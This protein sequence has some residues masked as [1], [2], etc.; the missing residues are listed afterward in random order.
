VTLLH[1]RASARGYQGDARC[2]DDMRE[3]RS[4]GLRLGL[5]RATAISMNNLGDAEAWY[6]DLATARATWEQAIAFSVERGLIGPA[7]WQRGERLRCL[8]HGGEWDAAL[9]ESTEVL[10]WE[11]ETGAGP[12]EVYAR[13]PMAGIAVH[14]GDLQEAKAHVAA[15][16][17][18]ARRSG[19]PQVL[20][21]GLSMAALVASAAGDVPSAAGYL[22][23]LELE[24]RHQSAWRSYCRVEPLRVAVALK[25]IDLG[26]AFLGEAP[27]NAGWDAC[28]YAT[29]RAMLA[30]ARGDHAQAGD[31]YRQAAALWGAYGSMLERGYALLGLGRCGDAGAAR[32]ADVIFSALGARPVLAQAA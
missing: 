13:L 4:L 17:A 23:E 18:A 26:E 14:R 21:P 24:T 12:L 3:A 10:T 25:R 2:V 29:A 31:S 30:E 9:T 28:A 11:L 20:I 27:G 19:D 16:V 22:E 8:Y 7:M 15:L 6:V 1:A 5:G 32:E